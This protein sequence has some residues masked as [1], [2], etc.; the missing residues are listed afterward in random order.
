MAAK[1][2]QVFHLGKL[3]MCVCADGGLSRVG[4]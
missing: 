4:G 1:V 2:D 3:K